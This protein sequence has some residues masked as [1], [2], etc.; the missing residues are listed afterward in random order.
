MWNLRNLEK[1]PDDLVAAMNLRGEN[2]NGEMVTIHKHLESRRKLAARISDTNRSRKHLAKTGGKETVQQARALR[3]EANALKEEYRETEDSL[4]DLISTLP[5]RPHSSVPEGK[6]A[7]DNIEV[8]KWGEPTV[9]NFASKDHVELG[10]DLGVLDLQRGAKIAGSGFPCLTGLGSRLNRALINFMLDVHRERRGYVEVSPPFVANR[11]SFFGT[12]QLPKFEND[13]YWNDNGQLGLIPTAEVPLTNLY[14]GEIL[15]E[16]QLPVRLAAYS[17]CWRQEA[18]AHGSET[19]GL[20]RVHQFDKIELV[21]LTKPENSYDELESLTDDAEEIMRRL[22][23]PHRR[24]LLCSGDMGFSAAKTYD[25]EVWLPSQGNYREI[26]SCSNCEAFQ[27]ERMNLRFRRKGKK[28]EY[29]H[30]LN[31]SGLAV[32]RT[33]VAIL[34]NNQ[35]EDGSIRV[36]DALV[37]YLGVSRIS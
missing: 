21:K 12:A 24:V 17:P 33:L 3:D 20:I 15:N 22:K 13:L 34:E 8:S 9:F 26:S 7:G 27:A 23:L 35:L 36:P 19:R 32:G 25:L 11:A 4:V 29:V 1:Q 14:S 5:N 16:D 6:D 10:T 28:T 18:G 30:T 37:P 31:G 2:L